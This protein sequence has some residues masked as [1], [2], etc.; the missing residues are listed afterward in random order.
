[1]GTGGSV[2][3]AS[4]IVTGQTPSFGDVLYE[5]T[6][7]DKEVQHLLKQS[8]VEVLMS[9]HARNRESEQAFNVFLAAV[10]FAAGSLIQAMRD[11]YAAFWSNE[12][13][14]NIWGV[15]GIVLFTA[16]AAVAGAAFY[17]WR[18]WKE[19]SAAEKKWAEIQARTNRQLRLVN[20]L[21]ASATEKT[22]AT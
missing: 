1:M 17:A 11:L 9:G 7:P 19:P 18:T 8:D 22:E 6:L 13:P 15:L 5:T 16:S 4:D 20:T 10:F 14:L 2:A 21:S 3:T 12:A